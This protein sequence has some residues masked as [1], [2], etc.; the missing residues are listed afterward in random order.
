MHCYSQLIEDDSIS[1]ED[2]LEDEDDVRISA[3]ACVCAIIV[4]FYFF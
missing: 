4:S 1:D 2:K 3:N